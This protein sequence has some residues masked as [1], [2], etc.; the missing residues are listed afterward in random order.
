MTGR[1]QQR[2]LQDF[3]LN[4][5]KN[6]DLLTYMLSPISSFSTYSPPE[7]PPD[8]LSNT[9]M[10]AFVSSSVFAPVGA[11]TFVH[12]NSRTP[13]TT[14]ARRSV[15]GPVMMADK[16]KFGFTLTNEKL[17]GRAAMLGFV[18]ALVTEVVNKTHPTIIDQVSSVLP[19]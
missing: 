11:S 15:A 7:A 13:T 5:Y 6:A 8:L 10:N 14:V 12:I 9:N 17:N 16:P 19:F 2:R 4:A 18:I 3:L 1:L